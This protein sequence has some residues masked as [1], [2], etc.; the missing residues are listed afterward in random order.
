VVPLC[1][2]E[3]FVAESR[4]SPSDGGNLARVFPGRSD[5][6]LTERLAALITERVLLHADLLIDLHTASRVGEMPILVGY[7]DDGSETAA[8]SAEAAVAF[9]VE[10]IYVHPKLGPGRTLGVVIGNGA[11]ALYTEA[12]GGGAVLEETVDAFHAGVL[13][14][15]SHLGMVDAVHAAKRNKPP[16][17]LYGGGDLENDF[18]RANSGGILVRKAAVGDSVETGQVLALIVDIFG[19]EL[20]RIVAPNDGYL[21]V[22]TRAAQISP[23]EWVANVA[24]ESRSE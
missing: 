7:V 4:F 15:L 5:G 11:S 13:S 23:G 8:K 6:S 17:M 2:E 1:N 10:A 22:L 14:V 9:G 18:A 24:R 12:P 19:N 3:A 21:A 20:E 16:R